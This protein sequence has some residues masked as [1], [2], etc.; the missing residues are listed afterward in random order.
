MSIVADKLY[1]V[2]NDDPKN[3]DPKAKRIATETP[4]KYSVLTIAEVNRDGQVRRSPLFQNKE[5]GVVVRPKIS[6][7]VGRRDLAIYG[8]NGRRYKFGVLTFE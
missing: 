2:Y 8:E 1:F 7:Q 3:L 4:D 6:K 5:N